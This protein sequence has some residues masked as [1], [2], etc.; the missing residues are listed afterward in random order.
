M[1]DD[2]LKPPPELD[3]GKYWMYRGIWVSETRR[4]IYLKDVNNAV[5][6]EIWLRLPSGQEK[7]MRTHEP[8]FSA[9]PGHP[10]GAL[11]DGKGRL[12]GMVN[13]HTNESRMFWIYNRLSGIGCLPWLFAL[14]TLLFI[15][16]D[17]KIFYGCVA[18]YTVL[19]AGTA[20][21]LW[22][23]YK[24]ATRTEKLMS[25]LFQAGPSDMEMDEGLEPV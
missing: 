18:Y 9:L 5:L 13:Y 20:Y 12:I 4:S 23:H 1:A 17:P 19:V 8:V 22:Q 15:K 16:L 6:R 14:G 21:W 11:F 24:K 7:R 25:Y 3:D 10:V 2:I